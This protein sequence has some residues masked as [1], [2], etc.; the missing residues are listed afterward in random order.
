MAP[1]AFLSYSW[2]SDAHKT[3]V[4]ELAK[5]LRADGVDA[6]IDQW[7]TAPGDQ[8]PA[9]MERAVADNDFVLIICTPRYKDRSEQR[10]GGVGYEGDI[11]TAE[12]LKTGNHRK[13]IPIL[14][15]GVWADAAP[16]WLS[17]KY[18]LDLRDTALCES[19]YQDLLSTVLGDRPEPPPVAARRSPLA[20]G[21][22]PQ[23]LRDDEPIRIL[24]VIVDKV[25]EPRMDG[26]EGSAL[27][28]VPV[29]LS[30]SAS[31]LWAEA[32]NR[33]WNRPPRFT[34]MHRPGIAR[35]SGDRINLNGTTIEEVQQYH[36]DTLVLC[37]K[38]T[39]RL[40]D[41]FNENKRREEEA[42]KSAS[43]DHKAHVRDTA[44]KIQFDD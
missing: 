34:S 9:F 43:R 35:A 16:N 10:V 30:R 40:V 28:N 36:R 37:V 29:R 32:F 17:G 24:G 31:A 38:E 12:L 26:T 13:F 6:I 2:D 15:N 11:I 23:P 18:Y 44:Q 41:E 39:N 7:A 3:W 19:Q 20:G 42:Q 14:R 33:V 21:S 27:Y 1:K 8:L 25:G 4:R 5:Q 22:P